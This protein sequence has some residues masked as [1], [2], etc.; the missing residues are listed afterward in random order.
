MKTHSYV[1]M[2][3]LATNT[4]RFIEEVTCA[5]G[6]QVLVLA[7]VERY[8]RFAPVLLSFEMH[9]TLN[10]PLRTITV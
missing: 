6:G 1:F 8:L 10:R 2:T 9:L 4:V 7:P 3:Q 5:H